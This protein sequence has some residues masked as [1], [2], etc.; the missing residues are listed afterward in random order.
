MNELIINARGE[1]RAFET[2]SQ[3]A[4]NQD[5]MYLIANALAE[6]MMLGRRLQGQTAYGG[7]RDYYQV[8][9][10]RD[11]I[12]AED[13]Y[14]RYRRQDIA[15]R[16]VN[17]PAID[18]FRYPPEISETDENLTDTPFV[19]EFEALNARLKFWNI[20]MRADKL[21]RIG[22]FGIILL[23]LRDGRHL[24]QP[25]NTSNLKGQKS[26]L[27]MRPLSQRSVAIA[28][29]SKNANSVRFGLPA[30]YRVT[31]DGTS[32]EVHW[33]RVI[34]LAENRLDSEYLGIP[35][36]EPV[37]NLLDDKMKAVGGSAEATWLGMRPG[38][39]VRLRE[40]WKQTGTKSERLNAFLDEVFRYAHDPLRFLLMDGYDFD[41]MGQAEIADPTGL[42]D[43]I[44]AD[45]SATIGIPQRI[46]TGSAAGALSAAS[47]DTRQYAGTIA[48]RQKNYAEPEIVRFIIDLFVRYNIFPQPIGGPGAY[49][50]GDL[51]PNGSY[52]W[53]SI[54]QMNDAEKADIAQKRA[55]AVQLLSDPMTGE[56]PATR[57][58]KREILGLP[59]EEPTAEQ[60]LQEE[61]D[62]AILAN[63]RN[64]HV[65]DKA[66]IVEGLIRELE[67]LGEL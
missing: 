57:E 33:S 8:L 19:D 44:L 43:I 26:V 18:T 31:L 4:Y 27:F 28:R 6:R 58:E 7:N 20:L 12:E 64:G 37:F 14:L 67:E 38:I 59:P 1:R 29:T 21:S 23:G 25:V 32:Y 35:A 2:S 15:Q 50:V 62:R 53:P 24:N 65:C 10:Y 45:I 56:S 40:G 3:K 30:A 17:L 63:W 39:I 66:L 36:L 34:H 60:E 9:G 48:A 55:S 11:T 61:V 46:L 22:E 13:Y 42:H 16:I 5:E 41:Q 52:A 54:I 51:Q 47:E 49:N